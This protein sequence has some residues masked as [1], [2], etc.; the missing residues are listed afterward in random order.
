MMKMD[1]LS[2]F[3]TGSLTRVSLL[4]NSMTVVTEAIRILSTPI[5][6]DM[7]QWYRNTTYHNIIEEF[8]LKISLTKC[9]FISQCRLLKTLQCPN[10]P[11]E[12]RSNKLKS[13]SRTNSNAWFNLLMM[14]TKGLSLNHLSKLNS[15]KLLPTYLEQPFV[16]VLRSKWQTKKTLK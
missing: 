12:G 5:C 13:Q 1:A 14:K 6:R 15:K 3:L 16:A 11:P 4:F 7:S 10:H 9:K 2:S 8:S